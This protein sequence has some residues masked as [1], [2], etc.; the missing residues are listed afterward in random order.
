MVNT[1]LGY[2]GSTFSSQLVYILHTKID[3]SS[4]GFLLEV[5]NSD[6]ATGDKPQSFRKP[7]SIDQLEEVFKRADAR[8]YLSLLCNLHE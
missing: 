1:G 4:F 6:M 5:V 7:M 2:C 3:N 8:S